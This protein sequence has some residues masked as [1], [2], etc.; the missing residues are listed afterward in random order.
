MSLATRLTELFGLEH[1]I[2]LGGMG[3]GA[4]VPPM[5]AAVSSAGGLGVLGVTGYPAPRVAAA[6]A[7][8]RAA[9]SRPFGL[10]LLLFLSGEADLEAVLAQRPA[11][12]S[13][14][15]PWPE[16]DLRPVFERAHAAG[17]RVMH[18][19]ASVDEARRAAEAGADVVV[20]QGTDGGGHVGTVATM[21]L[22]PM[23]VRAVAPV[24]VVAA[25]GIATGGQLAS[26]LLLG[27]EGV[28]MGTRFL[29]TDESPWPPSFKRAILD[30]DGH[31]TELTE[32]PDIAKGAVWPGAFDR[33]RRNRLISDW[34]GRENELRR[35]R[36][37]V[38]AAITRAYREDDA[39]RGELNFG[40]CAGLIDSI[41]PCGDLVRRIAADAEQTLRN[42]AG[43]YVR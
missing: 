11:V 32:I 25:G 35:R 20:A 8:I 16:Q 41:E 6:A 33:A 28:L 21:T 15:W 31:D 7:E 12:L 30:S 40:Q 34:S 22:V 3:G 29:A 2:V 1:P 9:C 42:A 18:M 38:A 10:N 26:A 4:T 23:A 39:E 17:V 5:V 27:A 14:A 13:T 37:E 19:V 43:R 36:T 24:P